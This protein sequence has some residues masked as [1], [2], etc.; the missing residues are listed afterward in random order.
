MTLPRR[1]R[2]NLDETNHSIQEW[3]QSSQ[4]A[5]SGL[6]SEPIS[7]DVDDFPVDSGVDMGDEPH[8][9]STPVNPSS[10]CNSPIPMDCDLPPPPSSPLSQNSSPSTPTCRRATP[11]CISSTAPDAAQVPSLRNSPSSSSV[12]RL[13][14][15]ISAY[16]NLPVAVTPKSSPTKPFFISEQPS[17]RSSPTRQI[18]ISD[19]IARIKEKAK[20]RAASRSPS[21]KSDKIMSLGNSD[22]SD[23]DEPFAM[24][25]EVKMMKQ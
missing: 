15:P 3:R 17:S 6:E 13:E 20:A 11:D 8:Q 22:D 7:I 1:I 5:Q 18:G 23:L 25:A 10:A 14:T 16:Q 12:T 9:S 4:N 24:L 21:E 2:K 19:R